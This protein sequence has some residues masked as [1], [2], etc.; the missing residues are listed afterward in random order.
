VT[1]PTNSEMTR[2][3]V[4]AGYRRRRFNGERFLRWTVGPGVM[5]GRVR[6]TSWLS[7]EMAYGELRRRESK[8]GA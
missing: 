7:T 6:C 8:A 4:A 5:L 3:L 1:K 2:A